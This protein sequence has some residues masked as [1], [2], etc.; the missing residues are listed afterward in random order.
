MPREEWPRQWER[1]DKHRK[2][3][4]RDWASGKA[5][6]RSAKQRSHS[7]YNPDLY[8]TD[9]A[10]SHL[11]QHCVAEGILIREDDK[12]AKFYMKVG[13]QVGVCCGEV[14]EFIF[15]EW[16]ASGAI[17]GRPICEKCLT[18]LGASI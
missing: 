7:Q 16:L 1:R 17:H 3:T 14:V 6:D 8:G 18:R 2:A 5:L 11:E 15:A 10:V 9:Q 4:A 13:H 12:I